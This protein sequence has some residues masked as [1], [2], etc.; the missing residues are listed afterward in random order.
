[1]KKNP[2]NYYAAEKRTIF[3]LLTSALVTVFYV[4][5]TL[6]FSV[7]EKH[8]SILSILVILAVLAVGFILPVFLKKEKLKRFIKGM[9]A[10][11]LMAFAAECLIF[12]FKSLTTGNKESVFTDYSAVTS[13]NEEAVIINDE[14]IELKKEAT[15]YIDLE[16]KDINALRLAFD[17][18]SNAEIRVV[19]GIKDENFSKEYVNIGEKVISVNYG[20]C[21]FAFNTFEE[22]HSVRLEFYKLN[23]TIKITNLSFLKAL[24]FYFSDFRFLSVFAVLSLI[25][26]IRSFELHK[27]IYNRKKRLHRGFIYFFS[28]FTALTA[29]FFYD[30]ASSSI[31]YNDEL[32]I[33][34]QDAFVQM[35]DAYSNG[36]LDL[37][38]S[39]SFELMELDNPYDKSLRDAE[40]VTAKW[41]R[42]YYDG[43]YYSYYGVTP[44]LVYYFPYY[45]IFG[46]LPTTNNACVFFGFFSILFMFGAIMAF[47]RKFI[48]KPNMLTIVLCMVSSLFASGI[49]FNLNTSDMYALPGITGTCFLMLCLWCGMEGCIRQGKRLQP[50]LFAVSGISFV[51]CLAAKPTRA[52]S[53]LVIAPVFLELLFNREIRVKSK[54]ASAA[55]FL[56]PVAAGCAGIMA[57]NYARFDSPFEFGAVYQLTVSNVNANRLSLKLFPDAILHYFI[58]PLGVAEKFPF[59]FFD[60]LSLKNR[61]TFIYD[62][63]S[64][65]AL[66]V[67]L[68]ALGLF[69]LPF[70]LHHYRRKKG[71]RFSFS[72]VIVKNWTYILMFV[73]AVF[74]AWFNYCVA[75]VILSYVC[76]ILPMLTLLAVFVIIDVQSRL[77][78][79]GEIMTKSLCVV[80]AAAFVTVILGILEIFSL[81]DGINSLYP[82]MIYN[83]ENI[84]SFWN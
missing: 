69:L 34:F 53:C 14:G 40:G 35:F 29:L 50:V 21:D 57:Y 1:M 48:E 43:K 63:F 38:F 28:V 5:L 16:K 41:D 18:E 46:K 13:N 80:S 55:S 61:Q 54:I 33:Y 25:A 4:V 6:N 71:E 11:C 24:P 68:I 66:S 49:Y 56:I 82:E 20:K 31:E 58:F 51:L 19:A 26:A 65:G 59:V 74:I 77:N 79:N 10:A 60:R 42:A 7:C 32:D 81:E 39:P 70:L 76:D 45:W 44:V 67:P 36:H 8:I 37:S 78:Y 30:G 15:I 17:G 72:G 75:G 84:F 22:L 12:N 62:E 3:F 9:T 27:I 23:D 52:L 47:V 83:A 64:M 2:T 73:I